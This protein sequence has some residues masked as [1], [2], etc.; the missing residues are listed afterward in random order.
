MYDQAIEFILYMGFR[1]KLQ[2]NF[3]SMKYINPRNNSLNAIFIKQIITQ[4]GKE[5]LPEEFKTKLKFLSATCVLCVERN[6]SFFT[7]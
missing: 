5:I 7:C 3:R 1:R 2:L 6:F 4:Y